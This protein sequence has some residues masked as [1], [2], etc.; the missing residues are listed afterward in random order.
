MI[1]RCCR[2]NLVTGMLLN[3]SKHNVWENLT[4]PRCCPADIALRAAPFVVAKA[5]RLH[6]Y[7]ARQLIRASEQKSD[8]P[9]YGLS[10]SAGRPLSSESERKMRRMLYERCTRSIHR[11]TI[12]RCLFA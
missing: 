9:L 4:I 3:L 11:G 12:L 1:N 8:Q 2:Y 10:D 7:F 6:L 5:R